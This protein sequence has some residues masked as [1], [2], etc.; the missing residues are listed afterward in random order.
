MLRQKDYAINRLSQDA[1]QVTN[2]LNLSMQNH[3]KKTKKQ[4]SMWQNCQHY[5]KMQLIVFWSCDVC[6]WTRGLVKQSLK[7][8][9]TTFLEEPFMKWGLNFIGFI[10][11]VGC[12][13]GNKYILVATLCH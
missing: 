4:L 3:L 7:K 13:I 9:V 1:S 5:S 6:Q 8:L 12:Y 11:L 2:N 10:K